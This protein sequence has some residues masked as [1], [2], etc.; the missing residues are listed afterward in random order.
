[1]SKQLWKPI[2]LV[3][4]EFPHHT[5]SIPRARRCFAKSDHWNNMSVWWLQGCPDTAGP[6]NANVW[7]LVGP[8]IHIILYM[9]I[10]PLY[11]P[12]S[13][14]F[15]PRLIPYRTI[16]IQK[17]VGYHSMPVHDRN[18]IEAAEICCTSSASQAPSTALSC[19]FP[20]PRGKPF[21]LGL[22]GWRF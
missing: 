11:T 9:N 8:C 19:P 1:M 5:E 13:E 16:T 12:H 7:I 2:H 6:W 15:Y 22:I 10:L 21:N 20:R 18:S 14:K 17:T 4:F 3:Q